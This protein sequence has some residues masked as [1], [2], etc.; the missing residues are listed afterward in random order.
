MLSPCKAPLV[1]S[2]VQSFFIIFCLVVCHGS[3][4]VSVSVTFSLF[5][6][7]LM[8]AGIFIPHTGRLSSPNWQLVSFFFQHLV[9][10]FK[11]LLDLIGGLGTA[12]VL[13]F[14]QLKLCA[15]TKQNINLQWPDITF[16]GFSVDRQSDEESRWMTH[17]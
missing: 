10:Y 5:L 6:A 14:P 9:Q 7:S 15:P 12:Y 2:E 17:P 8:R 4:Q 11:S 16:G 3:L 13:V 1:L